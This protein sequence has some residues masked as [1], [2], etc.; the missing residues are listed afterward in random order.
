VHSELYTSQTGL[1]KT[2]QPFCWPVFND[3]FQ[4]TILMFIILAKHKRRA[5]WW[6]LFW[7]ETCRSTL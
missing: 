6:W 7:T 1:D 3:I 2:L 5:P 4:L